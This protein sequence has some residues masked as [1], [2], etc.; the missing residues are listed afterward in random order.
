MRCLVAFPGLVPL[1]AELSPGLC[2]GGDW[3]TPFGV[4]AQARPPGV[5]DNTVILRTLVSMFAIAHRAS[6]GTQ[7]CQMQFRHDHIHFQN[8]GT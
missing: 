6:F 7:L 1:F 4:H 2:G 3:Y 8:R 5:Q